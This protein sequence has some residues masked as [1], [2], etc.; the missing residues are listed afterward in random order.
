MSRFFWMILGLL[1]A[2]AP[3]TPDA[4]GSAVTTAEILPEADVLL[5]RALELNGG[6]AALGQIKSLRSTGTITMSAQGIVA[7]ITVLQQV[8]GYV[9]TRLE[10]PGLGI[11]EE[12]VSDGVAWANDPISG[13]RLKSGVERVQALRQADLQLD[14][15]L[16]DVYPTR[17]TLGS[18]TA[19]AWQVWEVSLKPVEGPEEIVLID[20]ATGRRVGV[21][22]SAATVMGPIPMSM[23]YTAFREVGGVQFPVRIEQSQGP[24]TT[25]MQL[26]DIAVDA[27]DF[28]PLPLPE[29]IQALISQSQSP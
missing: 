20:K 16:A 28:A 10:L 8:P 15:H 29:D 11:M 13:P 4:V 25:V 7:P 12:G 18:S 5:D 2:C 26:H 23:L 3:K 22:M 19:G 21:R 6:A 27:P 24:V 14:A 17:R 9:Y 1:L